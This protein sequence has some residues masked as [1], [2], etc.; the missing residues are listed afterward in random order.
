METR[1]SPPPPFDEATRRNW[2]AGFPAGRSAA[3][4]SSDFTALFPSRG[5]RSASTVERFRAPSG[6]RPSV[7]ASRQRPVSRLRL[8]SVKNL[9]PEEKAS[10]TMAADSSRSSA[11][12]PATP[13]RRVPRWRG[14]GGLSLAGLDGLVEPDGDDLHPGLPGE[15]LGP[16]ADFGLGV[17]DDDGGRYPVGVAVDRSRN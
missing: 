7:I 1:A 14:R 9:W 2:R 11:T 6:I 10:G 12:A 16:C 13:R 8:A 3:S 17:V 5:S 4:S 15:R